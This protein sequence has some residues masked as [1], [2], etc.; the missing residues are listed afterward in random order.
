M[1]LHVGII[2]DQT[3]LLLASA[4]Q[5]LADALVVAVVVATTMDRVS[6]VF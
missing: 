6:P 4:R 5:Q 2:L 3:A 1:T